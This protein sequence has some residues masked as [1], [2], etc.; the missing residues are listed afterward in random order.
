[1]FERFAQSLL[2]GG[3]R[4]V[5]GADRGGAHGGR[6]MARQIETLISE[7]E[8]A[9]EKQQGSIDGGNARGWRVARWWAWARGLR[10]A[11]G[12]GLACGRGRCV[13]S[14]RSSCE[15]VCARIWRLATRHAHVQRQ[16]DRVA[17]LHSALC[18]AWLPARPRL[19]AHAA[20]ATASPNR[21]AGCAESCM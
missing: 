13:D 4:A 12:E 16:E 6:T 18:L 8:S 14:H 17:L 11:A 21:S 10:A 5:G 3:W 20:L 2:A 7:R 1:M 9:W 19:R 15:G